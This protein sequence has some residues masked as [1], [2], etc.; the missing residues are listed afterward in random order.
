M[1]LDFAFLCSFASYLHDNRSV[2]IGAGIDGMET[3][4]FPF[5]AQLPLMARLLAPPGESLSGHTC[6]VEISAP[7]GHRSRVCENVQVEASR[8]ERYPDSSAVALVVLNLTIEFRQ[9]GEHL[10]HLFVDEKEAKQIGFR[11]SQAEMG[12]QS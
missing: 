12:G 10:F 7:N 5:A 1:Q 9:K 6:R 4:T 2:I 8:D 11:V 3:A